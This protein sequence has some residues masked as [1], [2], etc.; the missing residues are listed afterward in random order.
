MCVNFQWPKDC[1]VCVDIVQCESNLL[2]QSEL[3]TYFLYQPII[4][5]LNYALQWT[6][7]V[8]EWKA[9]KSISALN[10]ATH[11][12]EDASP[13]KL[14]SPVKLCHVLRGTLRDTHT[15]THNY[16]HSTAR[17]T[18]ATS[19]QEK[20]LSTRFCLL[21]SSI[22]NLLHTEQCSGLLLRG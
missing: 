15:H 14:S 2:G 5:K 1:L 10:T 12:R 17:H 11:S 16:T 19:N 6:F 3:Y 4:I 20:H 22:C 13:C 21:Q 18:E 8:N 9:K 7:L